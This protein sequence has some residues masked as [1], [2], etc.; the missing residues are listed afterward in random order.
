MPALL[1]YLQ[2]LQDVLR[3]WPLAGVSH[4]A[5]VDDGGVGWGAGGTELREI[6]LELDEAAGASPAARSAWQ[7]QSRKGAGGLRVHRGDC[8]SAVKLVKQLLVML[9][10]SGVTS[11]W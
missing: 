6:L 1:S 4:E 5:V 7:W 9:V 10:V 2:L 11:G 3:V 8:T